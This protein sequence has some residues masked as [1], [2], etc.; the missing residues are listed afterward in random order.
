[1]Q[2]EQFHTLQNWFEL[3]VKGF[4]S[5]DPGIRAGIEFKVK[6]TRRVCENIVRIGRSLDL[7]E[8]DLNLAETIGLLHDVGRFKQYATYR[9]F[10]DRRSENHALLG[11]CELEKAGVLSPLEKDER[12]LILKAIEFHN[13]R[14][15]PE[16]LTDRCLMYARLIRDADKLDILEVTTLYFTGENQESSSVLASGFPDTPGY[17]PALVENL[18]QGQG[19]NYGDVENYNDRKL[20]LLS[21]VYDINF[22]YTLSEINRNGHVK[23]IIDVLPDTG[24]IRRVYDC[25]QSY[26]NGVLSKGSPGT[27]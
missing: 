27:V 21:W 14:E 4:Y 25:L 10:N 22:S 16:G 3:Y 12:H 20:L 18:L 5:G 13:L 23:K 15:L 19:C 2:R 7:P 1:M 26:M 11:I 9:T 6:H 24:D 8:K 17:S